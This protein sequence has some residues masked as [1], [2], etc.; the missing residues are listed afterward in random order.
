MSNTATLSPSDSGLM[1]SGAAK[2]KRW[3]HRTRVLFRIAFVYLLLFCFGYGKGTIFGQFPVV[4]DWI[5]TV[6]NWP[7]AHLADW[8]SVHI[9]HS[10]GIGSVHHDTGSGDTTVQWVQQ[11]LM[12]LISV[13]VGLVW[14]VVAAANVISLRIAS[15]TW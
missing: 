4:G 15:P 3:S 12:L 5:E 14:S 9:L 13:L 10:N 1:I 6:L 7:M 11:A 2:R 8:V